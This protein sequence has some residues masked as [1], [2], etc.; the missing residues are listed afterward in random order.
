MK[1][2]KEIKF[3]N[4]VGRTVT[5]VFD[6]YQ[7]LIVAF[8]DGTHSKIVNR[9]I[10]ESLVNGSYEVSE[11]I[12]PGLLSA[13]AIDQEWFDQETER[14]KAKREAKKM[15]RDAEERFKLRLEGVSIYAANEFT[16]GAD[17]GATYSPAANDGPPWEG[18]GL[19]HSECIFPNWVGTPTVR[20]LVGRDCLFF[21]DNPIPENRGPM[22]V[23]DVREAFERW[24]DTPHGWGKAL[25][26]LGGKGE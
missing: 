21:P 16:G 5:G 19:A 3:E 23:S 15:K 2:P 9:E 8:D 13:G 22:M 6:G 25:R 18:G 7:M 26:L 20:V 4:C 24:G 17:C 12:L 10:Y 1:E 14:F 11:G